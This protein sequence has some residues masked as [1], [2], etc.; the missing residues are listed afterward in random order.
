MAESGERFDVTATVLGDA[1]QSAGLT[2]REAMTTIR[3]A[4]RI[5]NRLGP[6]SAAGERL[7]TSRT[8]EGVRL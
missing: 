8:A 1:A 4:Y 2:E 6:P 7:G 3:S 5:A